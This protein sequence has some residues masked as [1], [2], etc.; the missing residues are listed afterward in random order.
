MNTWM[1]GVGRRPWLRVSWWLPVAILTMVAAVLPGTARQ[2]QAQTGN[3]PCTIWPST[4]V[5]ALAN[6][7]DTSSI[8]V[9]VKFRSDVAGSIAAIR[10]YKGP[11]NTGTHTGSL[12]TATGTLLGRA[13]FTNETASGWQQVNLSPPVA[14]TANT[15]YVA[16]YFAPVGRYSVN[17]PFFASAGVDNPPLHALANS[18]SAPGN[19]VYRYGASAFPN[20]S[21]NSSNYW[22]D[23]VFTTTTSSDTTPPTV[24]AMS[25]ANGA[26]NIPGNANV[27]ATFSE[28]MQAATISGASFELRVGT[29][30]VPA[31]VSYNTTTRVATL[32][33]NSPL[34]SATTYTATVRGGAVDPRVKDLAGNALA[35]NATWSFTTA[36]APPPPPPVC[37][38]NPIACENQKTGNPASEWD[39]AGA[40]HPSI[41]GFATEMSVDLGQTVHFKID[42]NATDYRLDIYR[43]G[44][45]G[46]LGA[47]R[48]ATVQPSVPLPQNQPECLSDSATGLVDCGNWTESASWAVPQDARSGIYFAKLVREDGVAGSSH[49]VFVVRDD[50]GQ[51]DILFQTS[52]TT[53]QAYNQYG[54][55]SL[56]VGGPGTSPNR[57][58][59]VSYNRPF[60]TRGSTPE[61]WLFNAEYPMVRWLERNGYHVSYSTGVDSDRRGAQILQHNVFLSVGHDEYWS[62]AQRANVKA[63]RDAGVHLAFLSG[64]EVFWKT[65]WENSIDGTNTPYRTLVC[66]KETHFNGKLDP[67]P[68]VWTGTWRDGREFNPE[69][70][71]PENELTGT[72]FTVNAPGATTTITVPEA[73][74]KMRFWRNTAIAGLNPGQTATLTSGTLGYEWDE[75]VQNA[76]RPAGLFRVSSTTGNV[77]QKLLDSGSTYGPGTATHSMTL[78]R[79]GTN[80]PLVFSAGTVQ[81]SWGLDDEHDRGAA[82]PNASLQQAVVNLFA[83]MGVQP[84][85]LQ[86]GIPA[87]ASSDTAAPTSTIISP[88]EGAT[89]PAGQ[90][91][92]ITGSAADS[93][94][95]VAAVEVSVDNGVTWRPGSGRASWSF[96]WTPSG[97]GTARLRS[98]AVDDSGNLENPSAGV[99]VTVGSGG[100]GGGCPCT[101][102]ASSATPAVVA[103]PDTAAVEVGIKFRADVDG[104]I[105]GIRFYKASTNTGTHIGNLW[106][107]GGQLLRSVTFTGETASGWQQATFATPVAITAN[108]TYVASYHTS[109]GHYSIDEN[110]FATAGVDRGPLHALASPGSGGNGVYRYGAAG[111]FPADTFN[112]TNYW[113]DIVFSPGSGGPPAG[114]PPTVT[115]VSPPE[116]TPGVSATT[117]VTATFSEPMDASTITTSTFELRGPSNVLVAA[118]VSYNAATQVATLTPTS[119]LTASTTYVATVRGGTTDPRAKDAG[120]TALAANF[121]WS[122]TTSAAPPPPPT[123]CPCTIWSAT[124]S[125]AT[126]SAADGAAVSLGVKF[127]SDLDGF[128]TGLRFYKGS[129]NTGTHIGNL[130]TITGQLLGS[131]TFAGETASGWQQAN[132]ATPVAIAANTT[133][134]ASYFAPVGRYAVTASYFATTGV[135]RPPLHALANSSSPNGL[136][137]YGSSNAFPD[138]TFNATNYWVDVV[139]NTTP[140]GP[141]DTTPPTVVSVTPPS[142]AAGINPSTAVTVRFSEP[143]NPA[144]VNQSTVELRTAGNVLVP[145]TVNYNASTRTGTLTPGDALA[146]SAHYTVTVRGGSTDPR[147]KDLA[148]NALAS[149]F[150][151][152]FSTAAGS[153]PP[154]EGPGGPILVITTD[155]NQFS[156]Y[157]AEIL[158]AE[159][160]NSFSLA[161]ISALTPSLLAA[162]DVV[163]LGQMPLTPS[164]VTMLSDWVTSGGNLIAMRPDKQLAPLLGLSDA[165]STLS[166]AY[167]L[168]DTSAAP[169][170]GIVGQTIQFKGTAD[171]YSLNGATAVATLYST[172]TAATTNPAVSV[173][174][175]GVLG[176]QAA[177]VTYDLA[178]S[179]IA[180]RQGN[181][182]WSG[183]ERDGVAPVRSDDLYFGNAAGDPQPDWINLDKVQIPQADEQQRLLANL[184]V[185]MNADRKPLPRFWYFPR[186]LKAVVVMTGDDHGNGG[187]LGRFDQYE[188][189]SP[190]NCSVENWECVRGTSYIYVDESMTNAAAAQYHARGFEIG[191]HVNTGC[192][193]WTPS[194]LAEFYSDQLAEFQAAYPSLPA[195]STNRTHC[196]AWSDWATQAKV[197][198]AHNIGLDTTYYYWPPSWVINRPGFF[199]G[200]GMPMRFADTDPPTGAG[201]GTL[202]DVYQA[203]SQMTDESG[204]SFPF[205]I[206]TL[207]DLALG[208]EGTVTGPPEAGRGYFGA[209]VANMHTDN[210]DSP[211]S[212]AIVASAQA[213]GVPVVS[214]RQMLEWLDGRNN[215]SFSGLTWNGTSLSFTVNV[216]Q[217]ANGLHVMVPLTSPAGT[218]TSITRDGLPVTFLAQTIKG[219]SWAMFPGGP[220]TYRASYAGQ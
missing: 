33:P 96:S 195:P 15:I 93:G 191:L 212:D 132:F 64:N 114:T 149:N 66:Y 165:G 172:A 218:L 8:E 184:I 126:A 67:L 153:L 84:A 83:D 133:Y 170:T 130:W 113:V 152:S 144:T 124:A 18:A 163:I 186:G 51:A 42:T 137:R 134:V 125:P 116:G 166:N 29:T 150:T 168:V 179:T 110:Y 192:A 11:L 24:T 92:T 90:P 62:G 204:Q 47:R 159:G 17:E 21:F 95:V 196:I 220:G 35:T 189:A 176:G 69:G 151:W 52:D 148:G 199:T 9:G 109:G 201:A 20:Q 75:D 143:M 46:G 48:V 99:T 141:A 197:E 112:A 118:A 160:L 211:G 41:Q 97:N 115:A 34:A 79:H 22:V 177:A 13:T 3:C 174:Q 154:A 217:G 101:L 139:F 207:L 57:A 73:D 80:G 140:G 138:Q 169:G 145:A 63:A 181:A 86:T 119:A 53:W 68:D 43:M 10:F 16:S 178:R 12:W 76:V 54:G 162:Y 155:Q 185:H 85:T 88:V 27:T 87:S 210:V 30:V 32:T 161:D 219:V 214:A 180:I 50:A 167:L 106:T 78:Y 203:T 82:A 142:G 37:T 39:I 91:V 61:D 89:L 60:T 28:P 182:A 38:S 171:R 120:G 58:Y 77:A 175:V 26:G 208:K 194:S 187:T 215:S 31:T 183:R 198:V 122:F 19:G 135:D 70:G 158:R 44:Y 98:R 6:D 121:S 45:Y 136:Y 105:T 103:D 49:I 173:R 65:R 127:R 94:G 108:T 111:T 193:D 71:R 74:G 102:W 131:V 100:G 188:A 1:K 14:I 7:P 200:S 206:D 146:T 23:V 129:A 107:S 40:G 25:P 81:W 216:G 5:P 164:Q 55:N 147:V 36:S 104:V 123:N 72:L 59:K 156:K 213:R 209:F 190:A 2:G 205:T 157:Y 128:I 56:Y 4:A 202:I 117:S